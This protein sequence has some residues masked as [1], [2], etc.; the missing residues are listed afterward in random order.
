MTQSFFSAVAKILEKTAT[1]EGSGTIDV[2][3]YRAVTAS[4]QSCQLGVVQQEA[5]KLR[6]QGE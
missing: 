6:E 4:G 5:N 3:T 2:M 1:V